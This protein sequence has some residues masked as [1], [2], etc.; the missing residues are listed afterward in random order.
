MRVEENQLKSF[1]ADSGLVS[2]RDIADA[3]LAAAAASKAFSEVL[4]EKGKISA[5][6][7]RRAISYL[8]GISYVDLQDQPIELSVLSLV[9]EPIARA[10]NIIAFK[11]NPDSLEVAML[12]IDDLAAIDFVER[13]AGLRIVPRLTDADSMK[14]ALLQYQRHLKAEFGDIIKGETEAVRS[15]V[16]SGSDAKKLAEDISVARIVDAI[17]R[18]ALIQSASSIH[19]EPMEEALLVRYRIDGLLHDAMVLPKTAAAA[20]VARIKALVGMKL[21]ETRLPQ[22]GRFVIDMNGERSSI[23]VALVPTIYGE[24]AVMHM[25]REGDGPTLESLGFH[26][27]ALDHLYKTIRRSE[28]MVLVASPTSSGA[29][30]TLY[31]SLESLDAPRASVATVETSIGR[32]LPRISQTQVRPDIGLT[33]A[34]ATRSALRQDPDAI[35][36]SEISDE[37]MGSL[38]TGASLAGC[39]VLST[40]RADSAAEMIERL[41]NMNIEPFVI[42][43]TLS[44]IIGE[45]SARRLVDGLERKPLSKAQLSALSKVIDLDKVLSFLRLEKVIGPK[46]GWDKVVFADKAVY[47]GQIGIHE[48]LRISPT[49]KELIM[50]G[51]SASEIEARAKKEGMMTMLE[52]GIFLAARGLTTIEE[53]LKV[54]SE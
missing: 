23:R 17:F 28:G 51:A 16:E 44:L 29:A 50:R 54:V 48:A 38:A 6:D 37:E 7:L 27:S 1:I 34:A 46:D 52:D 45:R 47:E 15:L 32:I 24:K 13:K 43:S 2:K 10:R 12:D 39:L 19:I 30:A 11:K 4:V 41:V 35:M 42:A 40:V 14:S 18:H 53:V 8:L 9:P 49:I 20:I 33:I 31:A 36:I 3:S 21:G 25:R 5:D 26:G 22:E